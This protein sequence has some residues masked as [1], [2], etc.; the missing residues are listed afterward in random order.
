MLLNTGEPY[1]CQMQKNQTFSC[2]FRHYA[3]HN[4]LKKEG[5]TGKHRVHLTPVK[6]NYH[7]VDIAEGNSNWLSLSWSLNWRLYQT[8][9]KRRGGVTNE[10]NQIWLF[11]QTLYHYRSCIF[12]CWRVAARSNARDRPSHAT[13]WYLMLISS[14]YFFFFFPLFSEFFL[15]SFFHIFSSP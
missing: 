8:L 6:Y 10:I 9:K 14:S 1:P 3:K 4:G 13:R 7:V 15:S 5:K 2:L 12:L 11:P